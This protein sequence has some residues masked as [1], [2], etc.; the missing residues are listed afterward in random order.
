MQNPGRRLP[1]LDLLLS[2]EA[3]AR[4]LSFTRAAQERFVTQSAISRQIRA[5]E[6]ELGIALFRR[7]HRRI[8]LTPAGE[9]LAAA[10]ASLLGGL[11]DTLERLRAPRGRRVLVVTTM[12]GLASLW[13]IPRLSRFMRLQPDVDVRIDVT[14]ER[15]DLAA[16]GID[17]AIR[18]GSCEG[19]EGHRLFSEEVVPVC[20]PALLASDDGPLREPADL[21]RHTL[22]RLEAEYSAP[23]QDW[24]PWL[25]AMGL[26]ELRSR[27]VLSFSSYH[28]VVAAAVHGQG[29]AL[30]RRPL[31]DALLEDGSL[32]T[33]F[34]GSVASARAYFVVTSPDAAGRPEVGALIDWLLAE[35]RSA[36]PADMPPRAAAPDAL[37]GT[38][39]RPAP[40][41]RDAPPAGNP[42][43][44]APEPSAAPRKGP[45]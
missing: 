30:G 28:E 9:E 36:R 7:A 38:D 22:L 29:V 33:P 26:A 6:D 45:R 17:V 44:R 5:L 13:L 39:T 8:L 18:Y 32:V 1:P 14:A 31:I 12:P 11:R 35:A 10:C 41:M 43:P 4:H 42:P 16:D 15:R 34:T 24:Q 21:A 19:S 25:T 3:A 27:A 40:D 20:S 2:F 23:L 37:P